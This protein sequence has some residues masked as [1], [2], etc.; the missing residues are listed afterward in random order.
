[1]RKKILLLTVPFAIF[2]FILVGTKTDIST[3]ENFKNNFF[4]PGTG[5]TNAKELDIDPPVIGSVPDYLE[6]GED[7]TVKSQEWYN[8]TDDKV[9]LETDAFEENKMYSYDVTINFNDTVTHYSYGSLKKLHN[10]SY[11]IHEGGGTAG[12]TEFAASDLFY[13]GNMEESSVQMNDITIGIEQDLIK[14]GEAPKVPKI[15]EEINNQIINLYMYWKDSTNSYVTDNNPVVGNKEY[16]LIVQINSIMSFANDFEIS[17]EN[18]T[19]LIAEGYEKN[20]DTSVTYTATYKIPVNVDQEVIDVYGQADYL[21]VGRTY[22]YEAIVYPEDATNKNVIW[23]VENGTGTA[24]I[25]ED[26]VLTAL[27]AGTATVKA[28]AADGSGV[29]GSID[30]NMQD[31]TDVEQIVIRSS[32]DAYMSTGTSVYLNAYVYP[33]NASDKSIKWTSSNTSIATIDPNTGGLATTNKKGVVTIKATAQDG[34]GV[35]G[36]LKLYVGYTAVKKGET[37]SLSNSN[38]VTYDEVKWSIDDET[39]LQPTGQYGK[40]GINN[41]YKHY[42]YVKGIKDGTTNVKMN[43]ISG[44]T[45][46]TSSVDVY[47]AITKINSDYEQLTMEKNET[48]NVNITIE[49]NDVTNEFNKI[50]YTSTD[51]S[52]VTVDQ[53]GNVTAGNENGNA[54]IVVYS[55]YNN[56]SKTIPVTVVTYTSNINVDNEVINLNDDNRTHQIVYEIIPNDAT[57]K[58]VTFESSDSSIATVSDTG[59]VTAIKNGTATI[60]I[61]TEDGKQSKDITV[62]VSGLRKDITKLGSLLFSDVTYNGNPQQRDFEIKD[63]NYTLI[64]NTDYTVSYENNT[65]VGTAKIIIEGINNYKNSKEYTFN[66]NKAEIGVIDSSSNVSVKYDGKL[67]TID[68]HFTTNPNAKIKYIDKNNEYTLD[69]IPSYSEVGEYIIKYKIYIDDN[70]TEYYG[71]R[72][73]EITEVKVNFGDVPQ[74]SWYYDA[75]KEA[76][77]RNI[78]SGYNKTTFAPSDKVTRGQLVTFLYRL[79]GMPD[80]SSVENDFD[81]VEDNMYFTD[82]VKWAK[83][84]K[85]VSGYG[86]TKKFG[87]N[88]PIIRQD[89]AVILNN[90]AKYKEK[91][92]TSMQEIT[93]FTDY[94]Y[95]KGNYAED[96]L[97]WA[98]KN[99][100]MSGQNLGNNKRAIAPFNNTTRAEAA[101]MI[102]NFINRFEI[103]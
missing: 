28:T 4:G 96:A 30:I 62:N 49:P 24:S 61:N 90:Y 70:Y 26:G 102:V 25:T 100:V 87:P 43:T 54:N 39:I 16:R 34:S 75:V 52:I 89:L 42:I 86:G 53:E 81:D 8:V 60:T 7:Y 15:K 11:C 21:K 35:Y 92:Y 41:Y 13:T 97:K 44:T 5:Q 56:I 63:G 83:S 46:S 50:I 84:N 36:T 22:E 72:T 47:T 14:I 103:N 27:S 10:S 31:F 20:S 55:Q 79:E 85:I 48:K 82:G 74:D 80:V 19:Y 77:A 91:D 64:K 51:N 58:N 1:M 73:L 88:D 66:I 68:T 23:S 101:A 32:K 95:V 69:T 9:M 78:I 18:T 33:N 38:Y 67:H 59:L 45:L 65:N 71:Q 29:V 40:T 94:D 2:L 37:T 17:N 99:K 6:D 76:Y 3:I 57:N 98:V 93:S 12:P